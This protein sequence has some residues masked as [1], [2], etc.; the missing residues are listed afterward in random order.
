MRRQRDPPFFESLP[1]KHK[2]PLLKL[3]ESM[4]F[5]EL[6][7]SLLREIK[8]LEPVDRESVT[9]RFPTFTEDGIET[10]LRRLG[11]R[12][13]LIA[14]YR[15]A[16]HHRSVI[17]LARKRIAY[18]LAGKGQR[19]FGFNDERIKETGNVRRKFGERGEISNLPHEVGVSRILTWLLNGRDQHLWSMRYFRGEKLRNTHNIPDLTVW[20]GERLRCFEYERRNKLS[21]T[22]L[23]AK[24]YC[25]AW[26][27]DLF[28]GRVVFITQHADRCEAL[29]QEINRNFETEEM[30]DLF[31][32][33]SE[34]EIDLKS[35][36]RLLERVL[37]SSSGRAVPLITPQTS[38]ITV[39]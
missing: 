1:T 20:F 24:R 6:T 36:G 39:G 31:C 4:P 19:L 16:H 15:Y 9:S 2:Q 11:Q 7:I 14:D 17:G 10:A 29:R 35:P 23:H 30:G 5:S 32:F 33:I 28:D 12:G 8:R 34:E 38:R 18:V 21:R 26:K 25:E 3:T 22:I 27:Q 37:M 13:Y